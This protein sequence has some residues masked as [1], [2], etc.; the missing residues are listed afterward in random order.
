MKIYLNLLSAKLGGQ[1][2]R[3]SHFIDLFE[4]YSQ[5]DD[6]LI[7]LLNK[8]KNFLLKE[9]FKIEIKK[10][11]F[12]E[13]P[14]LRIIWENTF[15]ILYLRYVKP[16]IYLTFS[17]S[18]PF[19]KLKIPTMVGFSNLA[20]FSKLA[21]SKESI[22]G[23]IR[24]YLLKYSII[25]SMKLATIVVALSQMGKNTLIKNNINC[26][27]IINIQIGVEKQKK[28]EVKRINEIKSKYLLYVSHFYPYKNFEIL[29]L[30]YSKLDNSI[31][32][33]YRL[34]LV[35]KFSNKKY[36]KKLKSYAKQLNIL[37][38]I[39]FINELKRD[40]LNFIYRNASLFIF[41]SLIEN[42]PN[43]LLE[44]LSFGLPSLVINL[45]PMNEFGGDSV[46]YFEHNDIEDISKK[47]NNILNSSRIRERLSKKAYR[48]SQNFNW[49]IFTKKILNN[50]RSN[51]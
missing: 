30:A 43:I 39:D 42:C 16:D 46:E 37:D 45:P 19:I 6:R 13:N 32:N 49:D 15:Q 36:V 34:K 35:G 17:H 5:S 48:H 10:V 31:R 25:H 51:L 9:N 50:C 1:I 41:T 20:P 7:V 29:I 33:N 12:L 47:I 26:K 8:K 2:T 24:L 38:N 28:I 40:E 44:S 3:A 18:L 11:S 14:I 27:K 21:I 4:K 23:R 22:Y